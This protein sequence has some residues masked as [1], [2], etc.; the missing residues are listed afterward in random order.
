M[1]N[2]I[3]KRDWIVIYLEGLVNSMSKVLEAYV[4]GE[5]GKEFVYA[6]MTMTLFSEQ[7]KFA[8]LAKQDPDL[9]DKMLRKQRPEAEAMPRA[10]NESRNKNPYL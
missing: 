1:S 6:Y 5:V 2:P 7:L 8:A 3:K 10:N 9:R 4:E